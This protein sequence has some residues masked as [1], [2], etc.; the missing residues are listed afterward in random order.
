MNYLQLFIIS[1]GPVV[2]WSVMRIEM[3]THHLASRTAE[4]IDVALSFQSFSPAED[5]GIYQACNS[6]DSAYDCTCPGRQCTRH[7]TTTE[8]DGSGSRG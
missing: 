6:Q 5:H 3:V 7:L 4:A 1:M 2:H 8:G